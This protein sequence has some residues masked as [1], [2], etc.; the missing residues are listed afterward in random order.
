MEGIFQ[1][2]SNP[3][4]RLPQGPEERRQLV[5]ALLEKSELRETDYLEVKSSF[6]LTDRKDQATVARFI[7]G[8][9]NREPE[10]A[11]RNLGGHA[12]LIAGVGANSICGVTGEEGRDLFNYVAKIIGEDGPR[13]WREVEDFERKDVL[14]IFVAPPTGEIFPVMNEAPGLKN[15]ELLIRGD[16]ET[17]KM[18]GVEIRRRLQKNKE[19]TERSFSLDVE[20]ISPVNASF[21]AHRAAAEMIRQQAYSRKQSVPKAQKP[22]AL[23]YDAQFNMLNIELNTHNQSPAQYLQEIDAW[24][25][26]ALQD[27]SLLE[28][29]LVAENAI[30]VTLRL[31][32]TSQEYLKNVQIILELPECIKAFRKNEFESPEM[33]LGRNLPKP[34]TS[35]LNA[36]I[37]SMRDVL[38]LTRNATLDLGSGAMVSEDDRQLVKIPVTGLHPLDPETVKIEDVFL[39]GNINLNQE[40]IVSWRATSENVP[41]VQKGEYLVQVEPLKIYI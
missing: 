30:P 28:T 37:H 2:S 21:P 17:R 40:V 41:G 1:V 35:A 7:L 4:N 26:E 19:M 38:D 33:V 22:T 15:G 8:A 11:A 31:T 27:T 12:I 18:N 20:I 16:Q 39:I 3:F 6:N 9:A 24:T 32:V 25:E 23:P 14:F 10:I 29:A 5:N 36:Q 13:W 34:W